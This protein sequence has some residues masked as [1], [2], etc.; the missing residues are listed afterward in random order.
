M[1]R[2]LLAA[3]ATRFAVVGLAM[4][5]LNFVVFELLEQRMVAELANVLAFVAATQ[6][7][8]AVSYYWTWSTRRVIGGETVA[9]VLRRAVLFNGSAALAFG[10]NAA[11]FSLVYRVVGVSPTASVLI[12]TVASAVASFVLSSR[13][14]FARSSPQTAPVL[15]ELLDDASVPALIS[16][17]PAAPPP[18]AR[19]RTAGAH[20]A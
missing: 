14:V 1:L 17:S 4:T 6:V 16:S 3:S 2:A 13:L 8:F 15:P 18:V 20:R 10:V 7:N 11:V 19:R 9:S 12:A 5:A